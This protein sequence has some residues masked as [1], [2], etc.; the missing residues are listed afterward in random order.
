M[1][2][3]RFKTDR[4]SV[5]DWRPAIRCRA[6]REHLE[7]SLRKLL[8][9]PVLQHLPDPLQVRE[10][11]G[12]MSDWIDARAGEGEVLIVEGKGDGQMVGLVILAADPHSAEMPTL[13]IGYLLGEAF[14]GRGLASE[15][16]GGL[17][18]ALRTKGRIRLLG[19]VDRSNPAS[20]RVLQ[21]AGFVLD[22]D[23]STPTTEIFVRVVG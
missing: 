3:D 12:G 7:V 9:P 23:L 19:G 16:I 10:G 18:S 2:L 22:Q 11:P 6:T 17:L 5:Y 21:K 4:L 20:S 14:W 8:T 15:L 13:H 1:P